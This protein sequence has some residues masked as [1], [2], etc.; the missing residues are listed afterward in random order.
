MFSVTRFRMEHAAGRHFFG[1]CILI[2]SSASTSVCCITFLY[3]FTIVTDVNWILF[4]LSVTD[5]VVLR[6]LVIKDFATYRAKSAGTSDGSFVFRHPTD[7]RK[8]WTW[9]PEE[10]KDSW[11]SVYSLQLFCD[12]TGLAILFVSPMRTVVVRPDPAVFS[13]M[14]IDLT[15][16]LPGLGAPSSPSPAFLAFFAARSGSG[17][18][19]LGSY[20]FAGSVVH[21]TTNNGAA[22]FL[23]AS[24]ESCVP[25]GPR[26]FLSRRHGTMVEG[27]FS[28][29]TYATAVLR[30]L[31][32]QVTENSAV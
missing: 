24:I 3:F 16:S 31:V 32:P 4:P 26:G 11:L 18:I 10:Q 23:V 9:G 27:V 30:R 28:A 20:E 25:S 22:H 1:S 7:P 13:A 12:L 8:T 5:H 6:D 14:K 15:P 21:V 2:P 17:S 29:E 19:R